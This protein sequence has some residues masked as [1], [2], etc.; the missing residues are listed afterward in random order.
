MMKN[1][2]IPENQPPSVL[3]PITEEKLLYIAEIEQGRE[4]ERES[5]TGPHHNPS[6]TTRIRIRTACAQ[7]ALITTFHRSTSS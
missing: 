5:P 6:P 7:E 3:S 4:R 2:V 1:L